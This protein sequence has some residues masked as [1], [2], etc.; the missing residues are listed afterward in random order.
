MNFGWYSTDV[1]MDIKDFCA[2][3]IYYM[4]VAMKHQLIGMKI[5]CFLNINKFIE[6]KC[7]LCDDYVP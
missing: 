5:C 2:A 1:K 4:N 7:V 6:F 3:L